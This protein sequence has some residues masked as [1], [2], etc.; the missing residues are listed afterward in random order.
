MV[1]G[2]APSS[3]SLIAMS[4]ESDTS[5]DSTVS[6]GA[7][8]DIW[9]ALAPTILALSNLVSFGGPMRISSVNSFLFKTGII[10]GYMGGMPPGIPPGIPPGPPG[11][12]AGALIFEAAMTSSIFS[13]MVAA[14]VADFMAWALTCVG[15]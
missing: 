13:S 4:M 8:M 14:S 6:I 1:I 10:R 5:G 11:G 3:S 15:S 12:I 9:S 2:R 7:P